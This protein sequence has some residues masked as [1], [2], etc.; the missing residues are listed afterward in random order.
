MG[1]VVKF[2]G[3]NELTAED[4][5]AHWEALRMLAEGLLILGG[6]PEGYSRGRSTRLVTDA[7]QQFTEQLKSGELKLSEYVA[8]VGDVVLE[9]AY[10]IAGRSRPP[11]F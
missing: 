10:R 2:P 11:S 3:N 4:L 8:A 9:E 1:D 6:K 7:R 5:E